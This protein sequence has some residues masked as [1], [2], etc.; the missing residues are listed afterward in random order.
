MGRRQSYFGDGNRP[1]FQTEFTTRPTYPTF[2]A[3]R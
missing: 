2:D 3:D 1:A